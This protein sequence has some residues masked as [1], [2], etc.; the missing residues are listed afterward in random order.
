[1]TAFRGK[2]GSCGFDATDRDNE[3]YKGKGQMYETPKDVY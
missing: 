3:R 2:V 1:M